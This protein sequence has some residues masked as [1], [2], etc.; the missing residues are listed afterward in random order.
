[1]VL[2][3]V[4]LEYLPR[5]AR[6]EVGKPS[7]ETVISPRDF[8][9]LD[10]EN[11]ERMRQRERERVRDIFVN[12]QARSEALARLEGLFAE[13]EVMRGTAAEMAGELKA[14]KEREKLDLDADTLDLL[15][16][17]SREDAR[18]LYSV[19]AELLSAEMS[20][21]VSYDNLEDVRRELR[22]KAQELPLSEEFRRAV[23]D[24]GEAFLRTNTAYAAATVERDMEEAAR[25]VQ[26][27]FVHYA[28]GQKIVEKGEIITPLILASLG[29][30][31]S[32]SPVG[33]YQPLVGIALL[34]LVLYFVV[35]VYFR[36]QPNWPAAEDRTVA[37]LCL[38]FLVFTFLARLFALFADQDPMWGFLVPLP[39]VGLSLG[40]FL[41]RQLALLITALGGILAGILLKGNFPLTAAAFCGG[42]AACALAAGIRRREDLFR[43]GFE[44]S[45]FM[46]VVCMLAASL[47]RD[48]YFVMVAGA[49]GLGN[50]IFCTLLAIGA[51]PVLERISGKITP[52]HLLELTTPEHP[53]MRELI[54]KAPGTYS[55][56]IVVGNLAEA[57]AQS[58]GADSLL[59][60]VG[61][62]YHDVGKVKRSSFFV[63]NQPSGFDSHAKLNPNLSAL[64]ISAHVKE[65]VEMAREHKLPR[66]IVDIIKQ[67]HGTSLIRYFYAQ[68]L[69][70]RNGRE[71]VSESRFRYPGEKPRSKEAAIVMLAD[72]V[73]AAAKAVERPTPVKL[74]QIVRTMIKERL[75]D[76]QLSECNLTMGE[77][78]RIIMAFTRVLCGMYHERPEYPT[79]VKGEGA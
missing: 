74:E 11:T 22:R 68:A 59:A 66:E 39:L 53:L 30:A 7:T 14:L 46:A 60:R 27:V 69:K 70:E 44:L 49:L 63:E 28:V 41:D 61:A 38:V 20:R 21:P 31:G 3:L 67:H 35:M 12:P 62:Y 77:V 24:L 4:V 19:T 78:E 29:E 34:V 40:I 6:F 55:H 72:A 26:P 45:V 32:L 56:S 73:E 54:S 52:L 57:A 71:R 65:G 33:G 75:D 76:G 51:L 8:D 23:A 79:L 18:L 36:R 1:V 25:A 47:M 50:G 15:A 43:V 48:I 42:V 2:A 64:V 10:E 37:A 5:A 58:I 13:V 17:S 9:V 16:R